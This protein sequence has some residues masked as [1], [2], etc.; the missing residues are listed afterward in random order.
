MGSSHELA[1]I[2][3]AWNK[4]AQ[5]DP[6]WAIC[7]ERHAKHGGWNVDEFYATGVAEVTT[8]LDRAQQLGMQRTGEHALDFGCAAGRL[9]RALASSFEHVTGVDIAPEML[10]I[11]Q[12]D[13]PVASQCEFVLNAKPDLTVFDDGMFDLVYSSIV[14]Q[15]MPPRLS[16]VYLTEF[17]R[18]LRPG[19][20]LIVQLPTRPRRTLR[21]LA[22]RCLPLSVLGVVQ[23]R[24]LGY[25]APM[26]MHG[27]PEHDVVS[28][29]TEHELEVL[30]VDTTTFGPDWHERRYFCR[31]VSRTPVS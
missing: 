7:V 5:E 15:H 22:Y 20:S 18:V 26:Q 12:H 30:A 2:G 21:G 3:D 31:K 9:T 8:S 11:A 10:A 24:L 19:G 16:R 4:L 28:L 13:N 29:L 25:P 1:S 23:R 14:L 6:L 17:A 27:I